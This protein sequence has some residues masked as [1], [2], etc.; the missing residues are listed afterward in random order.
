[1]AEQIGFRSDS[2]DANVLMSNGIYYASNGANY[3]AKYCYILV[4]KSRSTNEII[5][6][7]FPVLG[8]SMFRRVYN[9]SWSSWTMI[10]FT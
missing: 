6:L 5:Q 2:Y 4:L 7:G 3:P 10:S 1:M 8:S 9:N